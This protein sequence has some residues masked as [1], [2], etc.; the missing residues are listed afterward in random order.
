[1]IT[2]PSQLFW[3]QNC[4]CYV[5][6]YFESTST[7]INIKEKKQLLTHVQIFMNNNDGNSECHD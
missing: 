3:S 1:M 4:D 2:D 5:T 6:N 7:A